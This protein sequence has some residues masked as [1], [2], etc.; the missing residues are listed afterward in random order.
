VILGADGI[1]DFN[2][3]HSGKQ[4]PE[5]QLC[6]FDVLALDGEYLFHLPLSMRL[7]NLERL[8]R[9]RPN[10]IFVNP[11]EVGAD[12]AGYSEQPATGGSRVRSP[13]E[14]IDPIEA[15]AQGTGSRSRTGS[16]LPTSACE[17]RSHKGPGLFDYRQA[18]TSWPMALHRVRHQDTDTQKNK[19]TCQS[20][21]HVAVPLVAC[22]L[23]A[24]TAKL[25]PQQEEGSTA[26]FNCRQR[27]CVATQHLLVICLASAE[28]D[29]RVEP[30]ALAS[31]R[32][33][34]AA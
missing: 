20:R 4:N 15:D 28:I 33:V 10:G 17:R 9:G 30:A 21:L 29:Q 1:S 24:C 26:V 31:C 7:A 18:A 6:A 32:M 3:L 16:I 11:F 5:V 19:S 14:A 8:L 23:S 34:L 2:A 12:W 13:S 25:I 27:V 22:C